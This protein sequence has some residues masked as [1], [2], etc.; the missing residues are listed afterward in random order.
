MAPGWLEAHE[1]R[2][3]IRSTGRYRA[4]H[5]I[6]LLSFR[7]W[8]LKTPTKWLPQPARSVIEDRFLDM[9]FRYGLG[10]RDFGFGFAELCLAQFHN[11]TGPH[12]V[13]LLSQIKR[14][15]RAFQK[16][17]RQVEPLLRIIHIQQ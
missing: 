8:L 1:T 10:T 4:A 9:V 17:F 15:V 12:L 6:M 11:G 13:S 14:F 2:T 16:P 7:F 5:F 3:G